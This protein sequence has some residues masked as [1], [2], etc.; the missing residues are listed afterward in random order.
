MI[1]AE[2]TTVETWGVLI[3]CIYFESRARYN[4]LAYG[5]SDVEES[6]QKD[7][8]GEICVYIHIYTYI[9]IHTHTH[10]YL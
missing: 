2:L 9:H 5:L 1:V 6:T 7:K 10:K 8:L 4:F 3:F